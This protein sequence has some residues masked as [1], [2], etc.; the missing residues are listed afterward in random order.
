[1]PP[2]GGGGGG[3]G[4]APGSLPPGGGGGGGGGTPGSFPPGGGG[5]GGGGGAPKGAVRFSPSDARGDPLGDAASSW[6][7]MFSTFSLAN[8]ARASFRLAFSAE[9]ASGSSAS[10]VASSASSSAPSPTSSAASFPASPWSRLIFADSARSFLRALTSS[11]I[12]ATSSAET[13]TSPPSSPS[14][15]SSRSSS[16]P[17]IATSRRICSNAL[18]EYVETISSSPAASRPAPSDSGE[19]PGAASADADELDPDASSRRRGTPA[20]P[21]APRSPGGAGPGD[22]PANRATR[23]AAPVFAPAFGRDPP[24]AAPAAFVFGG[25]SVRARAAAA[26]AAAAA[27]ASEPE[28]PEDPSP[29]SLAASFASAPFFFAPIAALFPGAATRAAL[30]PLY[31]ASSSARLGRAGASPRMRAATRRSRALP[32]A[33]PLSRPLVGFAAGSSVVPSTP[34]PPSENPGRAVVATEVPDATASAARIAPRSPG[35]ARRNPAGRETVRPATIRGGAGFES[36][37]ARSP[38]VPE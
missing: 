12:F 25:P 19:G 5:G 11:T 9:D 26:A 17:R 32:S 2:G 4:G 34:P 18:T 27:D 20:S 7:W 28:I 37:R 22:I 29:T 13:S 16:P 31:R 15:P 24:P 33:V 14:P 1:M 10:G 3:G 21:L 36:P 8:F 6:F 35:S 30:G 23:F 38:S